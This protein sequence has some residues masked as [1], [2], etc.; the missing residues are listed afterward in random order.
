MNHGTV[1]GQELMPAVW[2]LVI[3]GL[4]IMNNK[5]FRNKRAFAFLLAVCTTLIFVVNAGSDRIPLRNGRV[6]S[7]A[8]ISFGLPA[9]SVEF[10]K[11]LTYSHAFMVP[12]LEQPVRLSFNGAMFDSAGTREYRLERAQR[13]YDLV[14]G[15]GESMSDY[16]TRELESRG[17]KDELEHFVADRDSTRLAAIAQLVRDT[18]Q[19]FDLK[20]VTKL[21]VKQLGGDS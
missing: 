15:P 16:L 9:R 5:A 7:F 11:R 12:G 19:P 21:A 1:V 2:L 10:E 20:R 8:Q 3:Y 6:E 13:Y 14:A 18:G 17:I 4:G